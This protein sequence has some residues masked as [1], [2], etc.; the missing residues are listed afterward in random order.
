MRLR[1]FASD[2]SANTTLLFALTLPVVLGMAGLAV[3][4]GHAASAKTKMQTV[5]DS[6]ALAAAQELQLAQSDPGR[7]VAVAES[8]VNNALPDAHTRAIVD[9]QAASV[10]VIIDKT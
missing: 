3:E 10:Q 8:V 7:I 2:A 5:A 4:Y 6:A 9:T 1:R